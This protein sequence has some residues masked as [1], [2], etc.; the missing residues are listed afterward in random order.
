MATT[1]T[2]KKEIER[3]EKEIKATHWRPAR[4]RLH[5]RLWNLQ[6]KLANLERG[7]E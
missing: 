3:I 6:I 7:A 4:T 1:Q 5:K 2:I